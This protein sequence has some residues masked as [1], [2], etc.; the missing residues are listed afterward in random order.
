MANVV[1]VVDAMAVVLDVAVEGE[2]VVGV[3]VYGVLLGKLL[4]AG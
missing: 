3:A 2:G 1:I 4:P